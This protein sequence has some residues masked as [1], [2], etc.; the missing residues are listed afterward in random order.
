MNQINEQ[1]NKLI[2]I[3]PNNIHFLYA[4]SVF[5]RNVV[6]DEI[7]AT[8]ILEKVNILQES[9]QLHRNSSSSFGNKM[10]KCII[11]RISGNSDSLGKILDANII[12]TTKL[13]YSREEFERLTVNQLLPSVIAEVHDKWVMSS[14]ENAIS[15]YRKK[16]YIRG[17]IKNK[18]SDLVFCNISQK[19][20]PNLKEE[21]NFLAIIQ[22]NVKLIGFAQTIEQSHDQNKP[23]CVFLCDEKNKVIGINNIA[24]KFLSI[25]SSDI[26]DKSETAMQDFIHELSDPINEQKMESNTGMPCLVNFENMR[27][28]LINVEHDVIRQDDE[29]IGADVLATIRLFNE[30]YGS[31]LNQP[32]KVKVFIITPI[33]S[34]LNCNCFI[35]IM[36]K[37]KEILGSDSINDKL[38]NNIKP[39]EVRGFAMKDN[40]SIIKSVDSSQISTI[41]DRNLVYEFKNSLYDKNTPHTIKLLTYTI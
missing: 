2:E 9:Y 12:A 7:T 20:I 6:F 15:N 14:Y 34:N 32:V 40:E 37:A 33:G 38:M 35:T 3:D 10:N 21:F 11:L 4:Y 27:R 17:F 28:G 18:N 1:Y 5:L 24:A 22:M 8:R 30:T 23:M 26:N 29:Y 31:E 39:F 36:E 25:E 41:S 16:K 13:K 19:V